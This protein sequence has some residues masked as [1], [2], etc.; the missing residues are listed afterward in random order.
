MKRILIVYL[1]SLL[2][3]PWVWG[4]V[5][6]DLF[7]TTEGKLRIYFIGHSTLMF[8][9]NDLVIHIDPTNMYGNYDNAPAADLILITH[10]HGDHFDMRAI[11]KIAR[12]KTRIVAT[13]KCL[14]PLADLD[15]V[16][17]NNGD[18]MTI[19][20]IKILA[21]PAYN[22]RH[23]QFNWKPYHEEGDGNAYL[24]TLGD[25]RILIGG[26]T[27]NIPELKAL[28]DIDIAFLPMDLPF[29]MTPEM[30]ADLARSMR[31]D[32][33]YPYHYSRTN[34]QRLADLLREEEDIEVR[35]RNLR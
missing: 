24:L 12:E 20:G 4:Q 31:P 5:E 7:E 17:L 6:N 32:V 3:T 27:E 9:L 29:T 25:T 23:K 14:A 13:R 22:I 1:V 35:I 19:R 34:P 33:L 11:R 21:L 15:P 2:F 28:K 10:E 16:I 18:S 8:T 30:V 26:D